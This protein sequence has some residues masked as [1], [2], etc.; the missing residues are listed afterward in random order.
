MIPNDIAQRYFLIIFQYYSSRGLCLD[1]L[2]M[3]KNN[4]KYIK[5]TTYVGCGKIHVRDYEGNQ[6]KWVLHVMLLSLASTLHLVEHGNK[7]PW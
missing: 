7:C 6:S 2:L 1:F 3:P 4:K 5:M